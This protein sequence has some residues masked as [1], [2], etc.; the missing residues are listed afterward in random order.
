MSALRHK[1]T[2]RAKPD[3]D[4]AAPKG[5][6]PGRFRV[7]L[8]SWRENLAPAIYSSLFLYVDNEVII[9][10]HAG[11]KTRDPHAGQ[12]TLSF[13]TLIFSLA[14]E[15]GHRSLRSAYCPVDCRRSSHLGPKDRAVIEREVCHIGKT[16][17]SLLCNRLRR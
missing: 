3:I 5:K 16:C 12:C 15:N 17:Q 1:R 2:F 13:R 8:N 7:R 9:A 14:A 6:S 4:D 10:I 11:C